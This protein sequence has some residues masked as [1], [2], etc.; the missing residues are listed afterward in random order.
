MRTLIGI[1][2]LVPLM[3]MGA[4]HSAIKPVS[5]A[6][7]KRMLRGGSWKRG[8]PVP[9]SDL[10]YLRMTYRG[11]DG[12]DHSGEMV[13][14]KNVAKEVTQIFGTLYRAQYPVHRMRLVDDY[15]ASDYRSIEADNT[16]AFNCRK[17]MGGRRWSPHAFG[18][19]IDINPIENPYV[20]R[21]G[22][23][24]HP[25]SKRFVRRRHGHRSIILPG[26]P[27][28]KTFRQHGWSWR[29]NAGR[30]HDYQHFQKGTPSRKRSLLSRIGSV[31]TPKAKQTKPTQPKTQTK[32]I[33]Q[34]S[35]QTRKHAQAK[36]PVI[37][38][39]PKPPAAAKHPQKP[40]P[41]KPA[42]SNTRIAQ[43]ST[44]AKKSEVID[45]DALFD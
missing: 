29:G 28:V 40:T 34:K 32:P 35:Q 17:E 14:H 21:D 15:G 42:P 39:R 38:S 26:D 27:I 3:A 7:K 16:S 4:Y 44:P 20:F 8:C 10:R 45:V 11:F 24:S 2:L 18:Q 19:A 5:P 23:V 1:F 9:L 6:L 36:K 13:V 41:K 43:K 12:R 37:H 30:N 31:F 33:R 25:A 22:H